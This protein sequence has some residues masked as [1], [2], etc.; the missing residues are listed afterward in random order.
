MRFEGK[1]ALVTG[2]SNGIGAA[3]AERLATEGAS[4]CLLAAPQ[5]EAHL[6]TVAEKLRAEA[7]A[8]VVTVTGDVGDAD[9]AERALTVACDAFGG[10]D[11]L[12][13]N[14]GIGI[15]EN[16]LETPIEDFD[17]VMRVNTRGQYAVTSAVARHMSRRGG[18]AMVL[19]ASTASLFGE[20]G[21]IIYNTSKG[22]VMALARSLAVDLARYG[23]RVNALAP[24]WVRTRATLAEVDDVAIWSKHR[25]RIPLDRPGEPAE[26]AA[27]ACFL[28]SDDA[29]YMTGSVVMCDGG[30]TAGY[31]ASDWDAVERPLSPRTPGL[32]DS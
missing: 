15:W 17:R 26:L 25:T 13:S 2:A 18:G 1:N 11:L 16:V 32:S 23:I 3:I 10:V 7:G 14:A 4:L 6:E 24:G 30:L 20:E 29:S 8:K 12:A 27:V 21:Q 28:L 5:D 9:T 19:T 31:R 22:A